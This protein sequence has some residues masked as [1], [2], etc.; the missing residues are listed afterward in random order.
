MLT[1]LLRQRRRLLLATVA[2]ALS[3]GYLAG[4]LNLLDR[5]GNGLD[6]LAASGSANADLVIEGTIAYE[7]PTE[8]VRRLVPAGVEQ[9]VAQVAGVDV[10][11]P[12]IEDTAPLVGPDGTTLVPLGLTEQPIGAN[13]PSDPRLS[14]FEFVSG[15][16]P[17]TDGEVAIDERSA[18]EGGVAVGDQV[19]VVGRAGAA[20]YEVSGI[21][22]S[23]GGGLPP[24]SSLALLTTAEARVRFDRPTDDNTIDVL[25]EP[26]ADADQVAAAISAKLPAGIDVVDGATGAQHRQESL[27]RSFAL[28][29]SL[30]LGFAGLALVVGMVTV[31][32]SLALL[33]AERRRTF[34]GLR[35]VGAK[36]WQLLSAALVEAALLA[37]VASLLGAPLGLLLGRLIEGALGA[38]N[39]SVP[40]AG[41]SVSFSALGS[42]VIIGTVATVVA[43]VIPAVR[44]CRVPPIEAVSHGGPPRPRTVAQSVVRVV[45]VAVVLG[46]AAALLVSRG[47][48]GLDPVALGLGTV[49]VV[50]VLGLMPLLLSGLVSAM[51]RVLPLRPSALRVIASRDVNRHRSRTAA[52]AA[53]LILATA[54][55]SGL[56][57]FLASFSSSVDGQV[58]DLVQADLV[59]DSG[60]FTKGGLPEDLVSKISDLDP[61]TAT[62]GWQVGR[63]WVGTR[64]VRMTGFDMAEFTSL[65][66]P[67]WVGDPPGELSESS[68]LISSRLADELGLQVGSTLPVTFTS[69]GS[70][71]L[72]VAGVYTS[73]DLLLG[74]MVLDRSVLSRQVPAT[75]DI[76]ALVSLQPDDAASRAE[77]EELA[78]QS[79][80]SSVLQPSAFVDRRSEVLTGFQRVVEWMLLFTLVQA[81][82]GVV[83]T[84]LLSVGERRRE[85][86]LLRASGASRRQVLRMVLGEGVSL[87]V[88]GTLVGLAV[89][90][91]GARLGVAALSSLGVSTFTVP[92]GGVLLV[93]FAA[94]AL[95]LAATVAPA[96]WASSVP[97]LEAVFD[98]GDLRSRPR[99][100]QR[101]R[102]HRFGRAA[103]HWTDDADLITDPAAPPS[104]A[105]PP[106]PTAGLRTVPPPLPPDLVVPPLPG[107]AM[108]GATPAAPAAAAPPAEQVPPAPRVPRV[109]PLPLPALPPPPAAARL[110][111]A[112]GARSVPGTGAGD[113]PE[114]E[115]PVPPSYVEPPVGPASEPV[116]AAAGD[117]APDAIPDAAPEAIPEVPAS[118][119]PGARRRAR[120]SAAGTTRRRRDRARPS[121]SVE[122]APDAPVP[123]VPPVEETIAPPVDAA[124]AGSGR[125]RSD[126]EAWTLPEEAAARSTFGTGAG[127]G[128]SPQQ[129][130]GRAGSAGPTPSFGV[131]RSAATPSPGAPGSAGGPVPTGRSGATGGFGRVS[132]GR[133]GPGGSRG[134]GE[135]TGSGGGRTPGGV[136][137]DRGTP[138]G[139]D[140]PPADPLGAARGRLDPR[141]ASQASGA[142]RVAATTLA[143]GER[144]ERLVAGRAKGLPC[145][146]A[147]TD[148]RLLVVAD[149]PGRPLVES[150]HA[151]QTMVGIEDADDGTVTLVVS[152]GRRVMR[153]Q[154]VRE[155][156]EAEL[157][158]G[159]DPSGPTNF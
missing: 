40:V 82:I 75:T 63:G 73:G 126:D 47:E 29:R 46:L 106:F 105:F 85:L 157:L 89:G 153:L 131:G 9:M 121:A 30:I 26:G 116:P 138:S 134:F 74:D 120:W 129:P 109:A 60:T 104:M 70:E 83:N 115:A 15:S 41:S 59:V 143:V 111:E 122:G 125:G 110:P 103:F 36:P 71:S 144:V 159:P 107:S 23:E 117:E 5:V 76:A 11:S 150:L 149:R 38:L 55:V 77:V 86:G 154:G 98:D 147:R 78:E 112:D 54:V 94:A 72:Q 124:S 48:A 156:A 64:P 21:V 45:L 62:S 13:Y 87:A 139:G 102:L 16:A 128:S 6:A 32:N 132:S 14:P 96:R 97:P 90:L 53:A 92:V 35:L 155:V 127:P 137:G 61:V 114:Q 146:V 52:T 37:V 43:A 95:G 50:V 7:S 158:V 24:G 8:Q 1:A 58:R 20:P 93:G 130:V 152:D 39:T 12:R 44:V 33:Y 88:V 135:P 27:D 19:I 80:V 49:A 133:G 65:M 3:V 18:A 141:S 66:R 28:V 145:V 57:V 34:A 151:H 140:G 101:P 81:L 67:G 51:V 100:A 123:P 79:G 4:A 2:I 119:P 42:A 84:L 136:G 91:V 22:E 17:S 108:A 56:A 31:G 142:L 10:V 25:L 148:R 113:L 118:A 99:R 69:T 68:A